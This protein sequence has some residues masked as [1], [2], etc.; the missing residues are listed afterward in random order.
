MIHKNI[1]E[2]YLKNIEYIS[3]D[4]EQQATDMFYQPTLELD[5]KGYDTWFIRLTKEED[6]TWKY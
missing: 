5:R 3:K 1:K 6:G 4:N 2:S